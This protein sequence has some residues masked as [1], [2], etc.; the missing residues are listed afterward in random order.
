MRKELAD[1]FPPMPDALAKLLP[2]RDA[3]GN[4]VLKVGVLLTLYFRH[5][6]DAGKRQ[7]VLACVGDFLQMFGGEMKWGLLG[8]GQPTPVEQFA[9]D[10]TRQYL[11]S[12]DVEDPDGWQIYWHGDSPSDASDYGVQAFG[13][14]RHDSE[15][16]E[17]LSYLTM[18]CPLH[19]GICGPAELLALAMRWSERLQ[20]VQGYGGAGIIH[21]ADRFVAA[22]G[23][24]QE[25]A[26]AQRYPTLEVDYPL[27]H[28]LWTRAGIK[29][30]NWLTVLS[31][32]RLQQL[33]QTS[34]PL[35][36]TAAVFA[37]PYQGGTIIRAGDAPVIVDRNQGEDI[38]VAYRELARLL[39]PIRITV[40]PAVHSNGKFSR[41]AFEGWLARFDS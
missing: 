20:P 8:V 11:E 27:K 26:L 34:G 13:K 16:L 39:Q 17:H 30:G 21:A 33:E 19:N 28:A 18:H 25:Y 5:G 10:A 6:H 31:D 23:E 12:V 2:V 7:A 15:E 37:H 3:K 29:G 4:A 14:C 24:V 40:H 32:I 22:H 38:P 36:L 35:A 41:Q 9:P 1:A